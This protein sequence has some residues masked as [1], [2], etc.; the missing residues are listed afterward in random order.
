[1]NYHSFIYYLFD[2]SNVIH[3]NVHASRKR[4]SPCCSTLKSRFKVD[5]W[6][7]NMLESCLTI[8]S[9]V[10]VDLPKISSKENISRKACN[11][12]SSPRTM[13]HDS[14]PIPLAP[15]HFIPSHCMSKCFKGGEMR[16]LAWHID[17]LRF[18]C[19]KDDLLASFFKTM[20][21]WFHCMFAPQHL[22]IWWLNQFALI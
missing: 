13:K 4:D 17:S 21:H 12:V 20:H 10:E 2:Y 1:M 5:T 9:E 8:A 14:T 19:F 3:F 16:S 22:F 18:K 6:S 11:R 7:Q 15:S